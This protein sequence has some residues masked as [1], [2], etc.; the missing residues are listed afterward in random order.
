[1]KLLLCEDEIE[2]SNALS[3]VLKYSKYEVDTAYDGEQ[4]L[5][6][7]NENTYDAVI[8]DI[9]MPKLDGLSVL[10]Q[11]RENNNN[12]PIIMVTAKSQV[13][14]KV[15]CLDLGANDY[16]TKPFETKELL[17]RLRVLT[18]NNTEHIHHNVLNVGNINLN[19]ETLE[20]KSS[21]GSFRLAK[22]ECEMLEILMSNVNSS[23]SSEKFFKK[24]WGYDKETEINIVW[25]YISYLKKKLESLNANIHI[26]V[27]E[28]SNYS[29]ESVYGN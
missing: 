22:Q 4:A 25:V 28:N 8:L 15:E 12:V 16:L 11:T 3:M 29:L 7:I 24:I 20:L 27:L 5:N 21:T 23:I 19:P 10:K 17:A 6:L 14:D 2:L 1:M 9:M 26:K 13:D 18:R